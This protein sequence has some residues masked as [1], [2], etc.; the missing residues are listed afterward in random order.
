MEN[1]V[2][3]IFLNKS[4]QMS[5]GKAAAQAAHAVFAS[6]AFTDE[7]KLKLWMSS[8][9]KTIIVLEARD[10]THMGGIRKY[11]S[12]RGFNTEVVIDEGVNETDPHIATALITDILEKDDEHVKKT[13][14]T[15]KLYKDVITAK[16]EIE[17]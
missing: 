5:A 9:H 16:I 12:Q 3:Y 13:F 1:P 4:F 10:M 6:A 14:S 2:V 17:R 15:F 7:S 8:A 11:L